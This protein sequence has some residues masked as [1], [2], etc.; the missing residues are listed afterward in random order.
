MR[1]DFSLSQAVCR[2]PRAIRGSS[3]IELDALREVVDPRV[4]DAWLMFDD[5]AWWPTGRVAP[6]PSP[7]LHDGQ[8]RMW[9]P[10]QHHKESILS[11]RH[12]RAGL[13]GIAA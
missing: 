1:D 13:A 6:A 5:I 11:C 4:E 8:E 7:H 3:E 10:N 2:V 9:P 12:S